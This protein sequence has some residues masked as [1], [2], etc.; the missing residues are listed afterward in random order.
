MN[1][2]YLLLVDVKRSTDLTPRVAER[3]FGTLEERLADL[4]RRLDPA[5]VLG[6]SISYGDEVAG[7]FDT[8]A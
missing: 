2:H 6:L 7:L 3:V 4:S 8:P 1:D 5:P